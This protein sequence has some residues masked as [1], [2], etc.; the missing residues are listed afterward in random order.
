[1][2][3]SPTEIRI[4]SKIVESK[5]VEN[6]I[7]EPKIVEPKIVE[8]KITESEKYTLTQMIQDGIECIL[9]C[10]IFW[11]SEDTKIGMIIQMI[12]HAFIYGMV[13]WYLYI[14]TFST[15][16]F[17]LVLLT[18]IWL[19]VWLQHIFCKACLF[20]NIQ[21]KLIGNHTTI[22]DQLLHLFNIPESDDVK[23]GVLFISSSLIM[24]MLSCEV[25]S[26]TILGIKQWF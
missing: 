12:H 2:S 10:V 14:H 9:R 11:E 15:S 3:I 21:Q 17:Q 24:C 22:I 20:F 18:F 6:E 5:I 23:N 19:L 13:L 4:E 25:L 8:N 1:M 16:Y 7:T 26:R